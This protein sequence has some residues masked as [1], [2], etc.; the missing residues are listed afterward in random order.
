MPS[1]GD[2]F[3][4]EPDHWNLRGDQLLW[5]ELAKRL[6]D[7]PLPEDR[8]QLGRLLENTFW[9]VTGQSLS[10][11]SEFLLEWLAKDRQGRGGVSGAAW[12]YRLF[13]LILER[14]E[15]VPA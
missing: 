4:E 8:N 15:K 12:R 5:Q 6:A 1:V 14:F 3:K 13:P 11:S 7:E 10:F 2:L 9:E